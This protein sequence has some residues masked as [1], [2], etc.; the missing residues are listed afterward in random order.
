MYST[1]NKIKKFENKYEGQRCFIVATGPTLKHNNIKLLR[2]EMV[3][4]TGWFP[5]H[6]EYPN[7]KNVFYCVSD[8]VFWQR[9]DSLDPLLYQCMITNKNT[10]Y[11]MES[12]FTGTNKR[13]RYFPNSSLYNIDFVYGDRKADIIETD[14]TKPIQIAGT[15]IQDIILPVVF[16]FGF[17]EIYLLGCDCDLDLK[18]NPD[19]SNAY[20][21]SLELMNYKHRLRQSNSK[22]IEMTGGYSL[23]PLYIKFKN[24]FEKH[25]RKIYNC[26]SG[27]K[28]DVFKRIELNSLF[29]LDEKNAKSN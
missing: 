23:E 14:L 7:L 12:T 13:H 16:Y 2:N 28:L 25:G 1:E 8:P 27:G 22:G 3:F 18:N 5:I 20:F 15:V 19:W 24:Y 6:I 11:F 26:T 17:S 9:T 21:Y 29:D 4:T 10:T